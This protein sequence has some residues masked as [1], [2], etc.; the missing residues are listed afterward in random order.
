M[1]DDIRWVIELT[2]TT[3]SFRC[4]CCQFKTLCGR[5][6]FE[7][8]PVCYWEDDGRDEP[9]AE[10]VLGGPNGLLSLRQAQTNFQKFRAVERRFISMVRP[11]LEDE[12]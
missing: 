1:G 3:K 7:I 5:G 4:P 9:D 10:K 12:L 11:P 6:G 2:G 8:C